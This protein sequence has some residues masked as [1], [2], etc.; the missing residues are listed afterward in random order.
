VGDGDRSEL[1]RAHEEIARLRAELAAEQARR[2]ADLGHLAGGMVHELNNPLTA[3]TIFSESLTTKLERTAGADPADLE[4]M[5]TIKE[6]GDRLLHLSRELTAYARPAAERAR[7]V[8]LVEVLEQAVRACEP[9]MQRAGA[10]LERRLA[11][12]PRV[13]GA[14]ASLVQLFVNLVSNAAQALAAGGGTIAL[15]LERRACDG[16]G[17]A[18]ARIVDDGC[19]M[20][21]EVHG[22]IFRPFFSTRKDCATGL[23]LCIAERIALRHGGSI[24]VASRPGAGTTV[25][26]ELPALREV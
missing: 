6:A 3:V 26:I 13:H 5:R 7:E 10:R 15:E 16:D 14:R 25:T 22:Q 1:Q 4:K 23:G 8:D 12:A 19:G 18:V 11:A 9:A 17:R 21:A 20:T 2:F 24:D